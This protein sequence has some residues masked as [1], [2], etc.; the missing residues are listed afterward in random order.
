M[1]YILTLALVLS[2]GCGASAP[3]PAGDSGADVTEAGD[4]VATVPDGALTCP[5]GASLCSW[6][7]D[8]VVG[9]GGSGGSLHGMWLDIAARLGADDA[10]TMCPLPPPCFVCPNRSRLWRVATLESITRDWLANG[11]RCP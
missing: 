6:S 8:N 3:G 4:V 11:H 5:E 2:L 10:V 7:G 9:P 1:R